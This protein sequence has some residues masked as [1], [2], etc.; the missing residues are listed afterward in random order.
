MEYMEMLF[1]SQ[2]ENTAGHEIHVVHTCATDTE[3]I[4]RINAGVQSIIMKNI[5][6]QIGAS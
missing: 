6:D 4:T 2:D 1:R 5:L 3:N